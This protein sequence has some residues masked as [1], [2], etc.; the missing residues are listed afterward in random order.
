MNIQVQYNG[1]NQEMVKQIQDL[2]HDLSDARQRTVS[3]NYT[4]FS[5][6]LHNEHPTIY[7][8]VSSFM[9]D[10]WRSFEAAIQVALKATHDVFYEIGKFFCT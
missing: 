10:I 7:R 5:G 1:D 6:W 8:Q 3:E 2:F 9:I 4:S